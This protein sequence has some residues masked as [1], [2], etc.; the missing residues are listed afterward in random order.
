MGQWLSNNGES[1]YG[2]TA[3]PFEKLD[4]GRCTQRPGKLY[5]HVLDWP[6]DQKLRVPG[7]RNTVTRAALLTDTAGA[8]E[9]QRDAGDLVITVP[10]KRPVR[11]D[12]VIVLE[13][14]GPADVDNTAAIVPP[15]RADAITLEAKDAKLTTGVEL[16]EIDGHKYLGKW[17]GQSGTGS[18][19]IDA[20]DPGQYR[21]EILAACAPGSEGNQFTLTCAGITLRGM[22]PATTGWRDFT[23]LYA[24]TIRLE[25][26]EKTGLSIAP[27]PGLTGPL[28]NIK[29]IRLTPLR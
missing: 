14:T 21:V 17:R 5:L 8:L 10:K 2:T 4:W 29:Q 3:S 1:I 22:V 25:R 23:L 26:A 6:D 16:E 19:T 15:A 18:W 7:L 9:F 20:P 24:G 11:P 27:G 28:M 12:T 13:I